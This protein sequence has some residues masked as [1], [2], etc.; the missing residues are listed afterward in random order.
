MLLKKR[1]TNAIYYIAIL[2]NDFKT[3]LHGT[4][5]FQNFAITTVPYK[6]I[7]ELSV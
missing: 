7:H 5:C 6:L 2:N 1:V 4:F 3:I